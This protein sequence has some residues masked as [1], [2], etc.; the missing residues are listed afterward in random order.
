MKQTK[1][2]ENMFSPQAKAE[3]MNWAH[4]RDCNVIAADTTGSV[5]ALHNVF[6][7]DV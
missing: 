5:Y 1:L 4:H 7:C 6:L 2:E 3:V